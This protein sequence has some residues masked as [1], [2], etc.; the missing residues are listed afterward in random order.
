MLV[1]NKSKAE[2]GATQCK[3]NSLRT[4][5]KNLVIREEWEEG[6][7]VRLHSENKYSFFHDL[8]KDQPFIK[9]CRIFV[10]SSPDTHLILR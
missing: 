9:L 10:S 6:I 2:F 3:P 8:L 7:E 1:R 4:L 5:I